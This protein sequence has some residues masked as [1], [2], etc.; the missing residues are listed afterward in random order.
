MD[1]LGMRSGTGGRLEARLVIAIKSHRRERAARVGCIP[2][3]RVADPVDRHGRPLEHPVHNV[4]DVLRI[5][6]RRPQIRARWHREAWN[7]RYDA[8]RAGYLRRNVVAWVL[9]LDG[10]AITVLNGGAR[11]DGNRR[12]AQW[13]SPRIL[14]E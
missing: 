3:D 4:C 2:V 7:Q 10:E 9:R 8:D 14:V 1:V 6:G 12:A 13:Q 5:P 11:R